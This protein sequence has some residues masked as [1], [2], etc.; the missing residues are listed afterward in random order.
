VGSSPR[1]VFAGNARSPIFR[2]CRRVG[3]F[4]NERG[5]MNDQEIIKALMVN[6]KPICF[7]E[8]DIR[9]AMFKIDMHQFDF[10]G[11]ISS[12]QVPKWYAGLLGKEWDRSSQGNSIPRL[13]SGYKKPEP[14]VLRCE[15]EERDGV[16]KYNYNLDS[17]IWMLLMQAFNDP[18]FSGIEVDQWIF[19]MFK[20][21]ENGFFSLVIDKKDLDD[22]ESFDMT[23]AHVLFRKGKE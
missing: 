21:K 12:D 6:V 19:G 2:D 20:H 11:D 17:D 9:E 5:I 16:L 15:I 1:T 22:Y 4:I 18:D 23:Q 8:G 13:R 7:M 3:T 14:E 10:V